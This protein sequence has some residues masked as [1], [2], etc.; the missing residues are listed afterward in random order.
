[1]ASGDSGRDGANHPEVELIDELEQRACVLFHH[2][3]HRPQRLVAGIVEM[4]PGDGLHDPP[5]AMTQA[6]P[7][8]VFHAP[9]VGGSIPGDRHALL[10]RDDAGHACHPQELVPQDALGPQLQVVHEVEPGPDIGHRRGDQLELRFG[11]IGR[12]P[13]VRQCGTEFRGVRGL[14]KASVGGHTKGLSLETDQTAAR[15]QR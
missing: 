4:H 15:A 8:D 7:I 9:G 10:S 11:E 14:G 13:G 12:N 1:M 2:L 5:V 3:E 6:D